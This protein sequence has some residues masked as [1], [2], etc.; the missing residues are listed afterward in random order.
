MI[1][2]GVVDGYPIFM[3]KEKHFLKCQLVRISHSSIIVP[4]GLYKLTEEQEGVAFK[5][6][7]V[8]FTEEFKVPEITELSALEG[9]VHRW[10]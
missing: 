7:E 4:S 9:W 6:G 3:G 5:R 8:E 10:P 1:L 2:I